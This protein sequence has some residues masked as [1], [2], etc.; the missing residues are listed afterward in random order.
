MPIYEP[1]DDSFLLEEQVK[2]FASGSVLDVGTGS[3]IQAI[4]AKNKGCT[5]LAVDIN[6]NAVSLVESKGLDARQSDLFQNVSEKFDFIIF[7]PPYLPEEEKDENVALYSA[8]AGRETLD[9]FLGECSKHLN[10]RGRVLFLQSS[11]TGEQE[12]KDI[13]KRL[14]FN[15]KVVARKRIFMEELMVFLA[16]LR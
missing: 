7:N 5:V 16:W 10:E 4:A 2:K 9:S 14:G 1:H 11:I 3:G 13:L 8:N 15:F 6:I 12:T